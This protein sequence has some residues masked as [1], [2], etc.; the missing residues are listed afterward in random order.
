MAS[1]QQKGYGYPAIN[2]G[3]FHA[4][5]HGFTQRARKAHFDKN[6]RKVLLDSGRHSLMAGQCFKI[7]DNFFLS[8]IAEYAN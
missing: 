2:K 1:A 6:H 8:Q 5:Q 7:E 4:P 3:G